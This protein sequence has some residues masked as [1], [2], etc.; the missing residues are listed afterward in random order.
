VADLRRVERHLP[1]DGVDNDKIVT[2]TVHFCE[3]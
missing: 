3:F 2:D 1:G